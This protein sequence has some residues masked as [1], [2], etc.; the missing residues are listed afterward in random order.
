MAIGVLKG[1]EL[2]IFTDNFVFESVYYKGTS[3][4]P[5]LFEIFLRLHQVQMRGELISHVIHIAGTQI[6]ESGMEGLSRGDNLGDMKRGLN[7]FQFFL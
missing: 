6:I 3:K 5:L 1:M 7:P 2:F 4:N